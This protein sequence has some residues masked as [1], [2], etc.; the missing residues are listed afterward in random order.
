[1]TS[2][3]LITLVSAMAE[4]AFAPFPVPA[5]ILRALNCIGSD[6]RGIERP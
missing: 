2:Q 5:F 6:T 3:T 1:M 4:T